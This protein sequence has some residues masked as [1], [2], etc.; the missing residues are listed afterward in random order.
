MRTNELAK[1]WRCTAGFY[2]GVPPAI[3]RI[4]GRYR[5]RAPLKEKHG[6]DLYQVYRAGTP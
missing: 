5:D 1:R 6:A 3:E 4:E 2:R